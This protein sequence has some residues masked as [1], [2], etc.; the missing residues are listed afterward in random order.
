[1]EL[2]DLWRDVRAV[3]PAKATKVPAQSSLLSPEQ[4]TR[5]RGVALVHRESSTLLGNF[6]EYTHPSGARRL[7]REDSLLSVSATEYVEGSWWLGEGRVPEERRPWHEQRPA[8]LH[9]FLPELGVH[10]PACEVT[11]HLSYGA[12]ARVELVLDT[13]FAQ[14]TGREQFLDLPAGTN[15]LEVMSLDSKLA[16]RKEIGL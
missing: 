11:A 15:I 1:M 7:I 3:V 6:S 13:R 9:L 8:I 10:A 12:I 4:W 5:T 16:L 2:E 14:T